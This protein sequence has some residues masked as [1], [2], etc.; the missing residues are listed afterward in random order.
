MYY[1]LKYFLRSGW[2]IQQ[3]RSSKQKSESVSGACADVTM[4]YLHSHWDLV[5]ISFDRRLIKRVSGP[6]L[7]PWLPALLSQV[8]CS[9]SLNAANVRTHTTRLKTFKPIHTLPILPWNHIKVLYLWDK[10]YVMPTR[11]AKSGTSFPPSDPWD[12]S[13]RKYD[14][15][16]SG[17]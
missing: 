13:R 7:P 17:I 1:S 12:A 5:N 2:W 11:H 10:I 16:F 15:K 9:H 8:I 3:W 6:S 4:I 14:I